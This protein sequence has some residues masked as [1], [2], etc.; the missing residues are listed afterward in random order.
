MAAC[1]TSTCGSVDKEERG[2]GRA[3]I[4]KF[5]IFGIAEE[6]IQ[7]M[8]KKKMKRKKK[9]WGQGRKKKKKSSVPFSCQ[10]YYYVSSLFL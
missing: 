8:R 2:N 4:S 5:V 3:G 10:I 1:L 9:G 6:R 7:K